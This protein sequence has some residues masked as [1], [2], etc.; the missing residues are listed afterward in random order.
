MNKLRVLPIIG[1]AALAIG[2]AS[3][4]NEDAPTAM[5]GNVHTFEVTI[6][7]DMSTRTFSDG[8]NATHLNVAFYD[9]A[10]TNSSPVISTFGQG[11][12]VSQV[13][14]TSAGDLKFTVNASLAH[15]VTYNVLF[16]ADGFG[17]SDSSPYTFDMQ[18]QTVSMSYNKI[19]MN[20]NA[21]DAFY[22]FKNDVNGSQP[23]TVDITLK[24]ALA[25]INVGT[26][27]FEAF[28]EFSS[29]EITTSSYTFSEIT[30]SINFSTGK[31]A[32]TEQN[33]TI[34]AT[35]IPVLM[36]NPE[37]FP[38]KRT[39][40]V[41]EEITDAPAYMAMAYVL[42]GSGSN[43]LIPKFTYTFGNEE[44]ADVFSS[45]FQDIPIR[46]NYRTNIYGNLLTSI[47]NFNVEILPSFDGS[48]DVTPGS[49]NP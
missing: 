11:V 25:Q 19:T 20:D 18:A 26:Y 36:D 16:W 46:Q 47:Y 14:V 5:Q 35:T 27:D 29:K 6:P 49:T 2:F 41:T 23:N 34:H 8:L 32:G 37:Y 39:D 7:A 45:F 1:V 17:N 44:N 9:K 28:S 33:V 22:F 12:N 15:G 42:A 43:Y 48:T 38:L 30:S 31:S 4:S 13:T 40:A 21:P 10:A 24:R 3:C